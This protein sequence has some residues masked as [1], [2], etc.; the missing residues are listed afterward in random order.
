MRARHR[1]RSSLTVLL[2]VAG[3]CA[4]AAGCSGD[5][6][7]AGGSRRSNDRPPTT[8]DAPG[9]ARSPFCREAARL[10]KKAN[11]SIDQD[12]AGAVTELSQLGELAPPEFSAD[13]KTLTAVVKRISGLDESDPKAMEQILTAVLDP[14]VSAASDRITAYAKSECGVDLMADAAAPDSTATTADGPGTSGTAGNLDLKDVDAVKEA[15]A[16][17]TW[18]D[19]LSSTSIVN[20]TDVEL[21]AEDAAL[22]T[23]DEALAACTAVRAALVQ[24]NPEVTLTVKSGSTVLVRAPAGSGCAPA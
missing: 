10:S 3:A 24:K 20:D 4:L 9:D 19:K 21:A 12:P 7:A 22:L 6:G 23:Q 8:T 5:D 14:D 2:L 17:A 13:F 1:P 18:P 16:S 11:P 15:N